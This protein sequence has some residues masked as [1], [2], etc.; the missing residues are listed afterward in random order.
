MSN[1]IFHVRPLDSGKG[2]AIDE[3]DGRGAW[4]HSVPI[5]PDGAPMDK[6][7]AQ[8]AVFQLRRKMVNSAK[9]TT[10]VNR[11]CRCAGPE[12]HPVEGH[13]PW[14]ALETLVS[15]DEKLLRDSSGSRRLPAFIPVVRGALGNGVVAGGDAAK[16]SDPYELVKAAC[17]HWYNIGW[18]EDEKPVAMLMRAL[19]LLDGSVSKADA[20]CTEAV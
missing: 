18:P 1:S 14:C 16:S 2:W 12:Y 11:K 19:E 9:P 17:E 4:Q 20:V 10:P 3:Y 8:R 13:D 6:I 5:G 7:Q 15:R